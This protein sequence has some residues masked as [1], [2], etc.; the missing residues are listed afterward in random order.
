M[1]N[2]INHFKEIVDNAWIKHLKDQFRAP[3]AQDMDIPIQ[4][5]LMPLALKTQ[6]DS[7]IFVHELKQEMH[8]D[9]K[10]VESLENEIDEL[11]SDKA[12]FS[13]MYDMILQESVS[14]EVMCTYLLSLSNLD[15]LA[16]L[17]CL[18]LHKVKECDCLA[19]NIS[20][21]TESVSNEVHTELLQCLAKVEKHSISLKIALQK[22]KERVKNNIVWNEQ[23]SNVFRKEREQYIK[24]Q[25]IKAQLQ[26][27]NIAIRVNHKTNVSRPQ[28]RSNQ[29]KDKVVPK[30]S[31]VKPKKTQVEDHPRISSISNKNKSI[32]ACNDSF[33]ART[34]N[35]NVVCATCGKCLVNSNHFACVTKLLNDVNARTK[36]PN[37]VPISTRKPIGHA[38]KYVATPHK[39]K[40]ASK[41]TTQKPKSYYRMPY[42]KTIKA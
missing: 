41:S 11:D 21:Q 24:I 16:E 2:N 36:K 27:K 37:I 10:Y 18:Y 19:Q 35:A 8:A 12:E 23:A 40:V 28:L 29:M 1:T 3:T 34:L 33:N 22:C 7:F 20:K 6:N 9:L 26:D 30:N 15:A 13:N 5:C 32:T 31:Q 25:D 39:K 14:N 42:E 17:Q 38:N 4:T